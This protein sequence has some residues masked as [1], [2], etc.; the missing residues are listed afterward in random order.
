MTRSD[1]ARAYRAVFYAARA[2]G[3]RKPEVSPPGMAVLLDLERFCNANASS[4]SSDPL[5]M[6]ASEGRRQVWLRVRALLGFTDPVVDQPP[7]EHHL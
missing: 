5:E 7:Q 2:D 3:A 1:L 6:A 4:W